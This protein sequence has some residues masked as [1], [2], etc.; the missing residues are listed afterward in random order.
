[1]RKLK[2]LVLAMLKNTFSMVDQGK[3]KKSSKDTFIWV[4]IVDDRGFFADIGH[5][6]LSNHRCR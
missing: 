2:S 3:R 6:A 4:C 5:A 1:M